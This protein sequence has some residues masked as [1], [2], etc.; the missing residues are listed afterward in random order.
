MPYAFGTAKQVGTAPVTVVPRACD[1]VLWLIPLVNV[2]PRVQRFVLGEH[3]EAT[4][5]DLLDLLVET[6]GRCSLTVVA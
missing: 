6:R 4:V 5:L 3:I 2:Y 1:L